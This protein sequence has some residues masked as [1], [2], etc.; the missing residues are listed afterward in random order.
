MEQIYFDEI[1]D[2]LCSKD[3]HMRPGK[4]MSSEAL[5]YK[6][7]VFAFLSRKKMVFRFGKD[8][9]PNGVDGEV[10]VFNPYINRP[11]LNGWFEVPLTEKELWIPMTENA[12]ELIKKSV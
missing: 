12:L 10:T 11:P 7:K 5:T 4:M 3:K 2:K 9:D 1:R 8:F 6:G